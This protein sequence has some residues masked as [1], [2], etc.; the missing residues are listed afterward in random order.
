MD[1]EYTYVRKGGKRLR[2]LGMIDKG[3]PGK[4]GNE[5]FGGIS[6]S[7]RGLFFS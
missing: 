1:E 3:I 6:G 5:D 7:A 2:Y 4:S